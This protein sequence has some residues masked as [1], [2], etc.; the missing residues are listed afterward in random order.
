MKNGKRNE[1]WNEF[2][3]YLTVG[4]AGD[5]DGFVLSYIVQHKQKSEPVTDR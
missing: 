1:K 3:I 4:I 5:T 2:E